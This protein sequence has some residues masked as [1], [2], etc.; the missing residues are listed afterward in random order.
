MEL[1]VTGKNIILRDGISRS[2]EVQKEDTGTMQTFLPYSR[3]DLCAQC[4][5]IVRLR[6]Q[7]YNEGIR[8]FCGG[9]TNAWKNHPAVKMW[10]PHK[11][12]LIEYLLAMGYEL[13]KRGYSYAYWIGWLHNWRDQLIPVDEPPPW[14]GDKRLHSSHRAN[15]LRKDPEWYGQFGWTEEPTEGYWWPV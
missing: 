9:S 8:I 12:Q 4:L 5:D 2:L 15:L 13:N 11:Y 6:N 1:A 14:I 7:F 10:L 3:Y